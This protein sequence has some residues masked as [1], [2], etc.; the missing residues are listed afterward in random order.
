MKHLLSGIDT[1]ECAY[2]LRPGPDCK[3]DFDALRAQ[4]EVM[5]QSGQ[6][7]E[8]VVDLGG[9]QFLMSPNGTKSGYPFLISNQHCAIQFGEFNN[10]AFFV[11]FR[12]LALWTR[13]AKKVHEQFLEWAAGLG[14][15]EIRQ[16]FRASKIGTIAGCYVLE[17]LVKRGAQVRLLREN[18]VA[19]SGELDSLKRFKDDVREVKE[20]YECGLSLKNYSEIQEGDR[21]EIY[22]VVEVQRTL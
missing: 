13:G 1:L 7:E 12:S 10:P 16:V 14:L 18:V 5:R 2:Y 21:L 3:L 6:P 17:G 22:E 9:E 15:V 20:G 8:G 4:K 11:T 19:W